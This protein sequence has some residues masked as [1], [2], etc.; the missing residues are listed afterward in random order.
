MRVT[1]LGTGTSQG[2][3]LVACDCSVCTSSDPRNQRYRSSLY[4]ETDTH[5]LIVDTT[6]DF[7]WQCLDF[8]VR[9][10]DAI[11]ITHCHADHVMGLDDVRR[12]NALQ[13]GAIPLYASAE[14]LDHLRRI[15]PYAFREKPQY[16]GY[17]C[18]HGHALQGPFRLGETRITPLPLP[19]GDSEVYGYLFSRDSRPACAYL[20]DCHDVPPSVVEQ[21]H[22]VPVLILDALRERPHPTHLNFPRALE[23]VARVQ[24][25][26]T[27]F[28]HM[29]HEVD[30]EQT[31]RSLPERV[32]LAYDGLTVEC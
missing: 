9:R 23:V 13:G 14:S 28:I 29:C 30:H 10:V 3:P 4:V 24:P 1:F 8:H 7:R 32:Q 12:F 18:F 6:L 19:H 21:I 31:N 11:L 20:T 15:F 26:Q 16:P 17:P 25:E 2:V 5:K 22:R 27:Y